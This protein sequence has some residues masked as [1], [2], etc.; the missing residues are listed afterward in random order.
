VVQMVPCITG[1]AEWCKNGAG[2]ALSGGLAGWSGCRPA[3][4]DKGISLNGA[5]ESCSL[6]LCGSCRKPTMR[7]NLCEPPYMSVSREP[8]TT[9]AMIDATGSGFV[10]G[11]GGRTTRAAAPSVCQFPR[12]R[13]QFEGHPDALSHR[14]G[15]RPRVGLR[16]HE[17]GAVRTPLAAH[18][19]AICARHSDFPQR[20]P[21]LAEPRHHRTLCLAMAR[22]PVRTPQAARRQYRDVFAYGADRSFVAQLRG[23]HRGARAQHLCDERRVVAGVDAGRRDLASAIYAVG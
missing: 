3:Q 2:V 18:H 1:P 5:R 19:Q 13:R 23:L 7:K 4:L 21:D 22:R 8:R 15:Q 6:R 11:R 10:G 17:R 16:R 20:L 9:S 12:C 14:P